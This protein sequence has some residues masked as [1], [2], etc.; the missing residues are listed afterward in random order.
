MHFSLVFKAVRWRNFSMSILC[1][2]ISAFTDLRDIMSIAYVFRVQYGG[3]GGS[4]ARGR[5]RVRYRCLMAFVIGGEGGVLGLFLCCF[6]RVLCA[7]LF[8]SFQ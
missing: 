7:A 4:S 3:W 8:W 1:Y 6:S 2:D 5:T